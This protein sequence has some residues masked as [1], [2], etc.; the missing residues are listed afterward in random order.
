MEALPIRKPSTVG[1]MSVNNETMSSALE[2]W[3]DSA[4]YRE[5]LERTRDGLLALNESAG[6]LVQPTR[7]D[8]ERLQREVDG[9]IARWKAHRSRARR[10]G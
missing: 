8:S 4:E 2:W 3:L 1:R 9:V 7:E 10:A 6:A 5:L